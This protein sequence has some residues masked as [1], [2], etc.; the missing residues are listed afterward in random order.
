MRAVPVAIAFALLASH[1][2]VAEKV[3]RSPGPTIPNLTLQT[4]IDGIKVGSRG[5]TGND[6]I[7]AQN[8]AD[9][10]S[11]VDEHVEPNLKPTPSGRKIK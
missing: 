8:S 9:P 10:A 3:P 2:A 4:P 7:P 1:G 5:L 6:E 11:P